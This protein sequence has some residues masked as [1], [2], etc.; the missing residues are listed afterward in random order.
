M[1]DEVA[2]GPG[3]QSEDFALA[4]NAWEGDTIQFRVLRV[5]TPQEYD[6]IRGAV[7][8]LHSCESWIPF[9]VLDEAWRRL[10]GLLRTLEEQRSRPPNQ[11]EF[12]PSSRDI[13]TRVTSAIAHYLTAGRMYLDTTFD[14]LSSSSLDQF[15]A[16]KTAC[17]SEFDST[18]GYRFTYHL[19]NA[20]Q[21]VGSLPLT[22]TTELDDDGARRVRLSA[23][24]AELLACYRWH[25]RVRQDIESGADLV[26]L[27]P[28][29]AE[30]FDAYVRIEQARVDLAAAATAFGIETLLSKFEG[31]SAPEDDA[32]ILCKVE[33]KAGYVTLSDM[34]GI[35]SVRWLRGFASS[36]A[37]GTPRDYLVSTARS[38]HAWDSGATS[39]DAHDDHG[40]TD[41]ALDV[42]SIWYL[43]G[44]DATREALD[45]VLE[46]GPAAAGAALVGLVNMSGYALSQ[47][48][49]VLGLN[50]GDQISSFRNTERPSTPSD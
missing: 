38:A 30:G 2:G 14:I 40:V 26:L 5:L 25:K 29:L 17:S 24:K 43:H 44:P 27:T 10:T 6:T 19:R 46:A 9:R 39:R 11:R 13:V 12:S 23:R 36:I 42:M 4:V 34:Q 21:H 41:L 33:R 35:P 22:F 47:V 8:Q 16:F 18:P 7:H 15:S 20:F 37:D 28:L 31:L 3:G 32:L 48:D 50:I 49:L 1:E 45:T